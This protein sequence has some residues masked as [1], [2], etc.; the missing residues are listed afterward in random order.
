MLDTFAD[1][2]QEFADRGFAYLSQ[3]RADRFINE[4]FNDLTLLEEWPFLILETTGPAPQTIAAARRI[5]SVASATTELQEADRDDLNDADP[6]LTQTGSARWWW[7]EG[8]TI[9]VYP[10]QTGTWTFR[11]VLSNVPMTAPTD[12]SV[13][14]DE[15]RH[16]GVDFAVIRALRDRSNFQEADALL[17][18]IQPDLDRM[19]ETF[20][21]LPRTQKI[22]DAAA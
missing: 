9:N 4:G 14:P 1:I 17:Q 7:R 22:T 8:S 13:V 21:D 3:S 10:L 2:R 19:R 15:W 20:I 12:T 6:L 16:L 18:A 5:L 11:V